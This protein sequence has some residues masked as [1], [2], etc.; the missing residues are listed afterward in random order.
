[1]VYTAPIYPTSICRKIEC[2]QGKFQSFELINLTNAY[3]NNSLSF[4]EM[5]YRWSCKFCPLDYIKP[6]KKIGKCTKC[7]LFTTS[8][9]QHTACIDPYSPIYLN[10]G[11]FK[12]QIGIGLTVIVSLITIFFTIVLL[13]LKNGN[14]RNN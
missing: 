13:I 14:Q 1:M 6:F 7:P 9:S 10:A 12:V 5:N 3:K 2:E 8:N 11:K 4:R